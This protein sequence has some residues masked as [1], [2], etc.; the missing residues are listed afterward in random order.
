MIRFIN[1]IEELKIL[2]NDWKVQR[3]EFVVIFGRRRIGKTTLL[4]EFVKN[5]IKET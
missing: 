4:N 5:F 1:R 3:N 2:E